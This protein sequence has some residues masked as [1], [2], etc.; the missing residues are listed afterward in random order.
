MSLH[1]KKPVVD[2]PLSNLL[3]EMIGLGVMFSGQSPWAQLMPQAAP[4]NQG[5][6]PLDAA[7]DDLFD[8]V[9]V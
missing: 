8:N 3:A 7:C 5:A 1:N 9:P 4:A 2:A 6:R